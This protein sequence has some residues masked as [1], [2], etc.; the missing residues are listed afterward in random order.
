MVL[1]ESDDPQ[2][3]GLIGHWIRSAETAASQSG[4]PLS[5]IRDASSS[6]RDTYGATLVLVR[7]DEFVAWAGES[8]DESPEWVLSRARGAAS[9]A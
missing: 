3:A 2:Q 6:A 9:V 1:G 4:V 5:V 8:A 7:P